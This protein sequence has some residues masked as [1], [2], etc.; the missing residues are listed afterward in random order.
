MEDGVGS[1]ELGFD[2]QFDR[3][4]DDRV[5]TMVV[6]YHEV[7][8]AATVG[9]GEAA[10]LVCGD[11]TSKFD[12]LEKNLVGSY[13]GIILAWEKNVGWYNCRFG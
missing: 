2:P 11:F 8:A 9:D 5:D 10:S 12:C 1:D 6:E 4:R 3:L 13:W 7:I